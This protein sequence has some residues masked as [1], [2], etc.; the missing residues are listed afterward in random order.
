MSS[1]ESP[2]SILFDALGRSLLVEEEGT[3]P[4]LSVRDQ[5]A[6]ALLAGIYEELKRI[7]VAL[8]Y[9]TEIKTEGM[10]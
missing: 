2:A 4:S 5:K 10:S 7:R 8:E 1:N 9:A 6:T 3:I